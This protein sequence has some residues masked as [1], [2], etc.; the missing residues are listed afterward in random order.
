V[1][2]C[3]NRGDS[4]TAHIATCQLFAVWNRTLVAILTLH[5]TYSDKTW[6]KSDCSKNSRHKS[7]HQKIAT[8]ANS[9]RIPRTRRSDCSN[10]LIKKQLVDVLFG[11]CVT[12]HQDFMGFASFTIKR[13]TQRVRAGDTRC[14]FEMPNP[15]LCM[16]L[17]THTDKLLSLQWYKSCALSW[18]HGNIMRAHTHTV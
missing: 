7:A 9:K 14:T 1:L 13:T 3:K 6:K 10:K 17:P 18:L 11:R 15:Y 16:V 5:S 12:M 8:L 2:K 4:P